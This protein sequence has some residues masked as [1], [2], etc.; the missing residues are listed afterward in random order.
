MTA[1]AIS[2]KTSRI[3][4]RFRYFRV[5]GLLAAGLLLAAAPA[6]AQSA[7]PGAAATVDYQAGSRNTPRPHAAY[8]E[9]AAAYWDSS[10]REAAPAH[11]QAP[12]PRAGRAR[13]LR[14]DAAAGL[15]PGRRARSIR[16]PSG[17]KPEPQRPETPGAPDF[18]KAAAEQFGF[19]P[20][21]PRTSACS[22][23][24]MRRRP[25]AAG[26]TR[27]QIVRSL[28][29]FE[30]GGNGT[31]DAQAGL[32]PPRP[33][34]R[35]ISPAVG[36]NQLLS[37]QQRQP[38]GRARR[39]TSSRRPAAQGER[40]LRRAARPRWIARSRRC[41]P[42]DRLQPVPCR[43]PGASTTGWRRPRRAASASTRSRS[44]STLVRCCRCASSSIP[45]A[46]RAPRGTRRAADRDRAGADELH[47]RRQRHRHGDDASRAA[48]AASPPR[49]S[50]SG[51][52]TSAI[53]SRGAPAWWRG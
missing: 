1:P 39:A 27:D 36:Y 10:Q 21:R 50:S 29:P 49:I 41:K 11:R 42:H 31:Y 40:A 5:M 23:A 45:C 32:V 38:A 53:R 24:P 22:S 33:N 12:Q 8:E 25:S 47:R 51:R 6:R 7:P 43:A 3:M 34:A 28:R 4:K 19:V 30:T 48:P 9:E 18:L 37:N 44:T 52:A 46:S 35:A 15:R 14:A 26:L 17:P 16:T 20:R 13:R 2:R